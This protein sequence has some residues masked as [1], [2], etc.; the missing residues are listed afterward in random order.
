MTVGVESQKQDCHYACDTTFELNL[1][2]IL[3]GL[4]NYE[5][6]NLIHV[7][8]YCVLYFK[9]F[10]HLCMKDDKKICF[11]D[12]ILFLKEKMLTEKYINHKYDEYHDLF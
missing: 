3:F 9:L 8:N 6:E 11:L 4:P 10:I 5:I 7:L 1:E 12:Y 2:N